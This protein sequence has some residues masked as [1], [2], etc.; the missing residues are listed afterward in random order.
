MK[1]VKS[2]LASIWIVRILLCILLLS[3][4]AIP[5]LAQ[6]YNYLV[7]TSENI[8]DVI[9]IGLYALWLPAIIVLA[10]LHKI[11]MNIKKGVIF[12]KTNID[13]LTII[14]LGLFLV[15]IIS[16]IISLVSVPFA[17]VSLA[18]VFVGIILL[19][20]RNVF[21]YAIEIKEENDFTI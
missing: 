19:V 18:F 12:E 8:S 2:I 6:C 3:I 9:S 20:V 17:F 5:F 11:L 1:S 4:F 14:C 15:G 7:N 21:K 16:L 10:L 13:Y